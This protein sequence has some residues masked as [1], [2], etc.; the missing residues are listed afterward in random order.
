MLGLYR[1]VLDPRV[2]SPEAGRTLEVLSQAE[3]MSGSRPL[4]WFIS[5]MNQPPGDPAKAPGISTAGPFANAAETLLWGAVSAPNYG[6]V[7]LGCQE[8]AT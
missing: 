6:S 7:S 1:A 2:Y 5:S 3:R 8:F 4:M